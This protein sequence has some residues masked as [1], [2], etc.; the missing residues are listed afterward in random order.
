MSGSDLFTGTLALL[1]LRTVSAEPLHG[2]A[3][4]KKLRSSSS[5]VLDVEEGVLYPALHRLRR[6][7]LV[8]SSWGKT[9]TGRRAKFYSITKEGR[10]HLEDEARR[11]NA[12]AEAVG[13]VLGPDP[14]QGRP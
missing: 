8:T 7:G 4:G 9:D 10:E 2:Y 6:Q 12:Y 11:W 5:D 3:I 1:I 13:N 14:S